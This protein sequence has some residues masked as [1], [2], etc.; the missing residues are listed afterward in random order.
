M[1]TPEQGHTAPCLAAAMIA[2]IENIRD[3]VT[4]LSPGEDTVVPF[5]IAMQ[6][7]EPLREAEDYLNTGL[8]D[9]RCPR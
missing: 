5:R 1:R 9:C 4:Y 7:G 6:N 3:A 2:A 8:M